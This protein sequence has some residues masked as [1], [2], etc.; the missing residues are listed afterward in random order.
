MFKEP[1]PT[2]RKTDNPETI[3]AIQDLT[4]VDRIWNY[5]SKLCQ[6]FKQQRQNA[7]TSMVLEQVVRWE[8]KAGQSY[9][10]AISYGIPCLKNRD[11][12]VG[13]QSFLRNLVQRFDVLV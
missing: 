9:S 8:M 11:Q 6:F 1:R 7:T 5:M 3:Q 13:K 4:P 2:G 12:Q 10:E